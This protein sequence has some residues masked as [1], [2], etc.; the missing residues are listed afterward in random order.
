MWISH[1]GQLILSVI[2]METQWLKGQEKD[3]HCGMGGGGMRMHSVKDEKFAL[4]YGET[5]RQVTFISG[6]SRGADLPSS[7]H[8]PQLFQEDEPGIP[9]SAGRHNLNLSGMFDSPQA[10]SPLDTPKIPPQG[11]I[12][13]TSVGSA[14]CGGAAALLR[15]LNFSHTL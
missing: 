11:R 3:V 13:A 6:E 9:W 5:V 1:I 4:L 15:R 7:G 14:Q 10:F 12:L 8:F 2:V